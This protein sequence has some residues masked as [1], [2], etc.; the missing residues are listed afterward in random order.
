[1]LYSD[2]PT[3]AFDLIEQSI[4]AAE[5]NGDSLEKGISWR[6]KGD[7]LSDLGRH[8]QVEDTYQRSL[9]VLSGQAPLESARTQRALAEHY[10][11]NEEQKK[12]LHLLEKA[13][14]TFQELKAEREIARTQ[15]LLNRCL[16]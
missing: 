7:I 5:E 14:D 13:F 16:L 9:S 4:Q 3:S 8:S 12:A 1:M 15:A 2:S 11:L 6:I 10:L